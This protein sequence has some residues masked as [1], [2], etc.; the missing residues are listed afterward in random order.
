MYMP[1]TLYEENDVLANSTHAFRLPN[2][3]CKLPVLFVSTSFIFMFLAPC[4][5]MR[6]LLIN[7][8]H[9]NILLFFMY[10]YNYKVY[11]SMIYPQKKRTINCAVSMR[12]NIQRGYTVE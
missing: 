4:P 9:S 1:R 6:V 7:N 10:Y 8:R 11:L 12:R 3:S 5:N 2:S